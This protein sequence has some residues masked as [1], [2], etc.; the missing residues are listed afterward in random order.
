MI[1]E[2]LLQKYGQRDLLLE[3]HNLEKISEQLKSYSKDG[4]EEMRMKLSIEETLSSGFTPYVP[5][6]CDDPLYAEVGK[7]S[8]CKG[9]IGCV[10]FA[11]GKGSRLGFSS[12]KGMFPISNV[13]KKSLFQILSEKILYAGKKY[14]ITIP[15][16]IMT[17]S[18]NGDKIKRF[19]QDHQFFGLD[20]LQV[21]FFS[22][23]NLPYCDEKGNWFLDGDGKIVEAATGNGDF[24]HCFYE[25]PLFSK[26]KS[27]NTE[28][29]FIMSVDNPLVLAFEEKTIGFHCVHKKDIT[30]SAIEKKE[31]HEKMGLYA[32][33]D[34]KVYILE[35]FFSQ[36]ASFPYGNAG[37]YYAS[38][39]FIERMGKKKS[40]LP[41]HKVKKTIE[42]MQ[43]G[44][45]QKV[46]AWK[47]ER[48]IFD[49]FP[50]ADVDAILLD[51]NLGFA[52]LKELEGPDGV[53]AVQKALLTRD[54]NLF[55]S[56]TKRN[57]PENKI[58]ELSQEFYYPTSSF[59][60]K[61]KKKPIDCDY[62]T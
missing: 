41:L 51:R 37:D 42:C 29:I 6:S 15:V 49:I 8:L 3:N 14:Q 20:P 2:L 58:F 23:E 24:W 30:A 44:K 56:L 1:E 39:S 54:R 21:D 57:L 50:F 10:I 61:W 38:F 26:Y 45:N 47:W 59:I 12:P 22:Q 9:K 16:A 52:P 25:S 33:K 48:F 62:L 40:S 32:Q 13:K 19:F 11:A 34:S 55:S 4:L 27:L 43:Q 46:I 5:P 31:L 18:H 17:S 53:A 35:Y 7:E 28:H 60:E 36:G